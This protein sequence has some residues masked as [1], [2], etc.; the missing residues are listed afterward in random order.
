M[1]AHTASGTLR[2]VAL[3]PEP[4][5]AG[6][7]GNRIRGSAPARGTGAS[8]DAVGVMA[9]GM[10]FQVLLALAAVEVMVEVLVEVMVEVKVDVGRADVAVSVAV[11]IVVSIAAGEPAP[12]PARRRQARLVTV[13]TALAVLLRGMVRSVRLGPPGKTSVP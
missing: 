12:Q 9:C 11:L 2:T 1:R 13:A 4:T 3:P 5:A 6:F 10:D 8:P 7:F